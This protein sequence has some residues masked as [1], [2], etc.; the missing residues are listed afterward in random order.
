VVQGID[1]SEAQL[2]F[3][4]ARS[5]APMVAFRQGDSGLTH[6]SKQHQY[7]DLTSARSGRTVTLRR[8]AARS[9]TNHS[10]RQLV[11]KARKTVADTFG[12]EQWTRK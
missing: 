3:A 10:P 4:R 2:G 7:F 12:E 9:G 5:A 6:R 8:N 11:L 1:P